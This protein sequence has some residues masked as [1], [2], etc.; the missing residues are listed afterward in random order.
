M[1]SSC[2]SLIKKNLH[3]NKLEIEEDA[4]NIIKELKGQLAIIIIAGPYRSGKSFLISQVAKFFLNKFGQNLFPV[5]HTDKPCTQGIWFLKDTPIKSK[6]N[7]DIHLIFMDTEGLES[8]DNEMW[9]TKLFLISLLISTVFIYNTRGTLSQDV[10]SKLSI[11]T[12]IT[13]KIKYKFDEELCVE[14]FKEESPD[15][16]WVIRDFFLHQTKS[17]DE[18]LEEFLKIDESNNITNE[19]KRNDAENRNQIRK[20]IKNYFNKQKCFYFSIPSQSNLTKLDNLEESQIESEFIERIEELGEYLIDNLRPKSLDNKF[21]NGDLFSNYLKTIIEAVNESET[22]F[23]H[24]AILKLEAYNILK[25]K[26]QYYDH[27]MEEFLCV[28]K[29]WQEFIDFENHLYETLRSEI[30]AEVNEV[31]VEESQI[32]LIN[33]RDNQRAIYDGKNSTLIKEF[34][35]NQAQSLYSVISIKEFNDINEFDLE[36]SNIK[37]RFKQ[38]AFEL[39]NEELD[40]FW[41]SFLIETININNI[42]SQIEIKI[43]YKRINDLN[44]KN[45]Q[46]NNELKAKEEKRLA[47]EEERRNEDA[48]SVHLGDWRIGGWVGSKLKKLF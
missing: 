48:N 5:G 18:A 30:D 29:S 8:Y 36:L 10:L 32:S 19:K 37:L 9:D 6:N 39:Y 43:G 42:K 27:K 22:F 24:D 1:S 35:F 41:D 23:V 45:I 38:V 20:N 33:H 34:N 47:E 4:L 26:L 40:S 17:A 12:D 13:N 25:V 31:N 28:K 2:I 14:K 44:E 7:Q 16:I 21:L 46:L 3:S 11:I 15:F